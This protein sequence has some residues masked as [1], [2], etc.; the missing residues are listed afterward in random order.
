MSCAMQVL[1]R[2][3]M[4]NLDADVRH[5]RKNSARSGMSSNG[6]CTFDDTDVR[7]AV[8]KKALKHFLLFDSTP[9]DTS[10]QADAE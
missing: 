7:N 1:V 2:S 4:G 9:T 3:D 6:A 5:G 8:R 10:S